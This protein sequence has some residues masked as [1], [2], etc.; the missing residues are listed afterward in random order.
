M[1]LAGNA[2][3]ARQVARKKKRSTPNPDDVRLLT[4]LAVVR[5]F[6]RDPLGKPK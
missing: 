5:K 3:T 6:K 1:N 2:P 4:Y